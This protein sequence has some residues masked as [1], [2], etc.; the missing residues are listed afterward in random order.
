MAVLRACILAAAAITALNVAAAAQ[1]RAQTGQPAQQTAQARQPARTGS[2]TRAQLNEQLVIQQRAAAAGGG[3]RAQ[4]EVLTL[5]QRLEE[6]DFQVGDRILLT[7]Q[8]HPELTDTFTVTDGRK[9]VLPMI[10]DLPLAGVLRSELE[11]YLRGHVGRFIRN[12]QLH[13][14]S[15]LRVSVLGEVGQP[16][17]YA[18]SSESLVTD[19]LMVAGG[20][21]TRARLSS[22]RIERGDRRV[23]QGDELQ[24]AITQGRTFD[25]LSLRAGDRIVVPPK[26]AGA[27][28][29]AGKMLLW[30]VPAVVALVGLF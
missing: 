3:A 30:A 9:L 21:T 19:A 28:G 13:A 7:V 4:A 24:E 2:V 8:G 23:M 25:Q 16:G 11:P 22:M 15:T 1:A 26:T 5:R 6:G 17:Y 27:L 29:E 12:P 14:R 10:G 18:I 20:P